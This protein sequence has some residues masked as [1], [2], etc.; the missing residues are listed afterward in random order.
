MA[1]YDWVFYV[2]GG[3]FAVVAL[4]LLYCSLLRDRSRG[5]R[6]CPKCWYDMGGTVGLV[7]S[8]CGHGA[9]RE[10]KLFKT[11]RRWRWG[12]LAV[13][14]LL[15]AGTLA[16]WPTI[17]RGDWPRLVP[18]TAL[19]LAEPGV[20][21][22]SARLHDDL[23]RRLAGGELWE[24]QIRLLFEKAIDERTP[25]WKIELMTR[26]RWP[27]GVD[28][29]YVA[30]FDREATGGW[31]DNT[32][33]RLRV[34]QDATNPS[35]L[36]VGQTLS[37]GPTINWR[38]QFNRLDL[39][40]NGQTVRFGVSIDYLKQE[41]SGERSWLPI[42]TDTVALNVEV[43]R[44]LADLM[45]PVSSEAADAIIRE[46]F[47]VAIYENSIRV[48]RTYPEIPALGEDAAIGMIIELTD[49]EKTVASTS[50][51]WGNNNAQRTSEWLP[52]EDG[53]FSGMETQMASSGTWRLRLRGDAELALR[54][55]DDCAEGAP[56]ATRYWAGEIEIPLRLMDFHAIPQREYVNW[57]Q[58]QWPWDNST[59][60]R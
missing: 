28:A 42:W 33:M 43:G 32:V 49:G 38:A 26:K 35:E 6:R 3:L 59:T 50:A 16:A 18:T 29:F 19:V 53:Q 10:R 22:W 13:V 5:R 25:P 37:R 8:E 17:Q 54:A 48:L 41:P 56:D 46:K 60:R 52:W 23:L 27:K 15:S 11:R 55:F 31:I 2:I 24:W 34:S 36:I 20:A 58:W 9:K 1:G 51:W 45:Q 30:R 4:W 21:G 47:W 44:E 39:P 57:G 14:G 12:A 7:C 40:Q